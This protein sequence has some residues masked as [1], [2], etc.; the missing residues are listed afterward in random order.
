MVL[1]TLWLNVLPFEVEVKPC[2]V[3]AAL[4]S[5]AQ[6]QSSM[7]NGKGTV[8]SNFPIPIGFGRLEEPTHIGPAAWNRTW[9]PQGCGARGRWQR[10]VRKGVD[11]TNVVSIAAPPRGPIEVTRNQIH[12]F[13]KHHSIVRMSFFRASGSQT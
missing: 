3:V 10:A 2:F 7:R 13:V 4:I 8:K 6:A 11:G 9:S 1:L 5:R 12:M